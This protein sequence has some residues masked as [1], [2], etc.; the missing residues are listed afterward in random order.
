MTAHAQ[1]TVTL[2]VWDLAGSS[3]LPVDDIAKAVSGAVLSILSKLQEKIQAG[4]ISF[5]P[6]ET[7]DSRI[8]DSSSGGEFQAP[9]QKKHQTKVS[10]Q[11]MLL[12]LAS[13]V[14]H[15]RG[16]VPKFW[17]GWKGSGNFTNHVP[18]APLLTVCFLAKVLHGFQ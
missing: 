2:S 10:C 12:F 14:V 16:F 4:G 6:R 5:R 13:V 9:S 1:S 8:S 17:F 15:Y 18:P 11:I 3:S 7:T